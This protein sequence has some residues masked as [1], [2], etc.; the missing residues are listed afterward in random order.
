TWSDNMTPVGASL[1]EVPFTG[2]GSGVFNSDLAFWGD[3]AV[4]GTYAGFR[5]IDVSDPANP[6]EI[7]DWDECASPTVTT[8]N[9]G[10]VIIYEN[11]VIRS[12]NSPAHAAGSMCGEMPVAAGEEGVHII[13]ISDPEDPEVIGFV[14][15]P[16]GS[17]TETLIPDLA[18]D[19]LIV[20]SNPSANTFLGGEPGDPVPFSCRGMDLV[21]VPLDAPEDASYLRFLP[22]G[23]PGAPHED[24]H[25]C[26]DSSVILGDVN[27]LACAGGDGTNVFSVGGPRGGSYDNPLWL[28]HATTVW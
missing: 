19:R 25:P 15:T 1:H 27:L 11:L 18:N 20:V 3:L 24:L 2:T 7:I 14:D 4:Q 10:D 21:E 13:D 5:L 26:H 12:W 16:C 8:G 6:Q 9:Q 28:Y 23:P 17:H 22:A